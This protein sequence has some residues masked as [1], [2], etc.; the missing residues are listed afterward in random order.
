MRVGDVPCI[1][2]LMSLGIHWE[3]L[4]LEAAGTFLVIHRTPNFV[5][6]VLC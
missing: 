2:F 3:A 5:T 1:F 4:L 6:E